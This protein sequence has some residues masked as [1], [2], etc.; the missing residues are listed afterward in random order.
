ME[1]NKRKKRLSIDG[2]FIA[3][4]CVMLI[5]LI[6]TYSLFAD[7]ENKNSICEDAGYDYYALS[8]AKNQPKMD[9]IRCC[10]TVYENNIKV[11]SICAGIPKPE[12][13]EINEND[14]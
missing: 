4:I 2:G 8:D 7:L 9:H 10:I 1:T 13:T 5:V 14:I 11:D 12:K 3:F 6:G